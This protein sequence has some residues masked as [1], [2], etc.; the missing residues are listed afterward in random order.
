M[1][2]YSKGSRAEQ[3]A[4]LEEMMKERRWDEKRAK[5]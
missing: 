5:D 3:K 1:D 4:Q 2:T